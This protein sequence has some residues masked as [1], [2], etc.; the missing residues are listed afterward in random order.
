MLGSAPVGRKASDGLEG[1]GDAD[2]LAGLAPKPQRLMVRCLGLV[3]IT[4]RPGELPPAIKGLGDDVVGSA[5]GGEGD[6]FVDAYP[7]GV[8]VAPGL[9]EIAHV[10]EH[11]GSDA[12][13][14]CGFGDDKCL[15]EQAAGG[16]RVT[17]VTTQSSLRME[18]GGNPGRSALPAETQALVQ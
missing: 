1:R 7:G 2:T 17:L 8:E 16:L 6:R 13:A 10:Q 11:P 5:V 15:G 12:L 3:A 4:L 18:G 9:R 14:S